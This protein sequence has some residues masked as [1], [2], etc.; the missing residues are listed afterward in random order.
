MVDPSDPAGLEKQKGMIAAHPERYRVMGM[1][2][3]IVAYIVTKYFHEADGVDF[4]LTADDAVLPKEVLPRLGRKVLSK[5][6]GVD[7]PTGVD[8]ISGFVASSGLSQDTYDA[9]TERL[10]RHS[11]ATTHAGKSQASN[12][13]VHEHDPLRPLL[14]AYGFQTIG[15]GF[16]QGI[17]GIHDLEQELMQRKKRESDGQFEIIPR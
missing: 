7:T 10:L 13:V 9:A 17:D 2:G 16:A 5:T 14:E 8:Y 15:T 3:H 11:L 4:V 1:N 12:I 6:F